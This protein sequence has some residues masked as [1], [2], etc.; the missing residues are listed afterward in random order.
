MDRN[1]KL[2]IAMPGREL[3]TLVPMHVDAAAA[4]RQGE[5]VDLQALS[6]YLSGKTPGAEQGIG[7]E[8]FPG[9]HSNL[10]YLLLI[11]GRE[12]VMRRAP[13]GPVAPKP[14]AIVRDATLLHPVP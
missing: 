1:I 8:Q 3:V 10:T 13:L 12:Y 2:S 14:H 5:E 6:T 4:V 9:G 7:I 11:G